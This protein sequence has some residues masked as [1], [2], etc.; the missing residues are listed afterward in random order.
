MIRAAVIAL[1]AW[2]AV[3][4]PAAAE[5]A[6]DA[7]AVI[8]GNRN[9]G[10]DVPAVTYAHN[11]ADA[12]RRFVMEDLGYREG[13]II[14][15]RDA[16]QGQ[17]EATFGNARSHQGKLWRWVGDRRADV[18]VFYSG[19]GV[20]SDGEALLLP[21][22]ADPAAPAL[23]GYPIRLLLDN[24]ARLPAAMITVYLD[25]CFSGRSAAGPLLRE[26]SG[27]SVEQATL[28]TSSALTV[29]TAAGPDEVANWDSESRHGLF[30][31]YLLQGLRGAADGE[32]FGNG[33]DRVTLAE[34]HRYLD[35]EMS[36][37]ARRAHGRTQ[38]VSVRGIT[39]A[40]LATPRRPAPQQRGP[41]SVPAQEPLR[42]DMLRQALER[43]EY[44]RA[45]R[46]G[47]A[48]LRQDGPDPQVSR[49][50]H[51][52]IM[53]DLRNHAGLKRI[54][55]AQ[56]FRSQLDGL[57][58]LAEAVDALVDRELSTLQ[59]SSRG[60]ARYLLEH[61][62]RLRHGTGATAPLLL[63]E[64]QSYHQLGRYDEALR[65]YRQWMAASGPGHPSWPQVV[66]AMKQAER[67]LLP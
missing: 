59:I 32:R 60:R 55:R 18:L 19:H 46:D 67:R 33:D 29:V 63:L 64:A 50:V 39:S 47:I 21:S 41:A 37:A 10:P 30:T 40:V 56:R 9:Y 61:L 49:M 57:S 17:L 48:L 5:A 16:T 6:R 13:N 58:S 52:A 7:V 25:T 23:N 65:A 62:P 34:L 15:L 27:L 4:L 24:L 31:R 42:V 8:I 54:T 66:N 43:G 44:V 51:A 2:I 3:A 45:A 38:T 36:Y 35:D 20:P 22:D 1:T 26:A 28:P 14:D 53:A 12:M 11:D